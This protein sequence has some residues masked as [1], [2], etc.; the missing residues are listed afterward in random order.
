[1][2]ATATIAT[3]VRV[4]T[5]RQALFIGYFLC[6]LVDLTVLNLFDEYFPRVD[7]DS[8]TTSLLAAAL[9][10]LLLK[11]TLGLEH[12]IADYF[13][14]QAGKSAKYKR[15]FATWLVLFGSKFVILEAINVVFG[16]KVRFGGVIPFIIVVIAVMAAELIIN[17]IYLLLGDDRVRPGVEN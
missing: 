11:L 4:L 16:D 6:V 7:I 9:L 3:D 10:Q 2:T 14:K 17:R 12:R 1:M 8:F 13:K 15:M 5:N